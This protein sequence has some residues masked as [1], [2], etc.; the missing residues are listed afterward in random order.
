M[1]ETAQDT[2][3]TPLETMGILDYWGRVIRQ[4]DGLKR[5]AADTVVDIGSVEDCLGDAWDYAGNAP[6]RLRN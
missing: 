3:T 6:P 1:A 2:G 4:L 5:L